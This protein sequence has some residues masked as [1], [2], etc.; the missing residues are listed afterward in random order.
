MRFVYIQCEGASARHRAWHIRPR[1]PLRLKLIGWIAVCCG[2]GRFHAPSL[3]NRH[4]DNYRALPHVWRRPGSN[5]PSARPPGIKTAPISRSALYIASSML[6][7]TAACSRYHDKCH[8]RKAIMIH[9]E[10]RNLRSAAQPR[11][12]LRSCQRCT[13]PELRHSRTRHP[14]H[15]PSKPPGRHGAV[16]PTRTA[17]RPATSLMGVKR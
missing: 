12:A 8:P 9:V 1:R 11:F 2:P 15:R 10:N 5:Q 14:E 17:I 3:I 13:T 16:A 6:Y 4:V 7:S